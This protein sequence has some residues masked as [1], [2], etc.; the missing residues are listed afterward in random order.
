VNGTLDPKSFHT[1]CDNQGPTLTIVK[2][3]ENIFGGYNPSPWKIDYMRASLASRS[4]FLFSLYTPLEYFTSTEFN[5]KIYKFKHPANG[6]E[7]KDYGSLIYYSRDTGP[8]FCNALCIYDPGYAY[9]KYPPNSFKSTYAKNFVS[10]DGKNPI[11]KNHPVLK[12]P[13]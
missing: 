8:N 5:P 9:L 7:E 11:F 6:N 1:A 3:D 13:N 10:D 2:S 12:T 4:V